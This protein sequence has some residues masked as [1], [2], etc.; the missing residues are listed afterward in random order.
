MAKVS[1]DLKSIHSNIAT[2]LTTLVATAFALVAALAWNNA[3]QTLF[4]DIFGTAKTLEPM[5]AYA[6]LVTIIAVVVTYYVSRL[7]NKKV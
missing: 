4:T 3:I 7:A 1:E 6:I 2:Q 5:F